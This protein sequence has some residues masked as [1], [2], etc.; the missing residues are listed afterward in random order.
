[1]SRSIEY[2]IN[3]CATCAKRKIYTGRTKELMIPREEFGPRTNCSRCG[4]FCGISGKVQV[5]ISYY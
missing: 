5:F 3:K 1:M 2:Y 4:I